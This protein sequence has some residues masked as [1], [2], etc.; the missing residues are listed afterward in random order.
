MNSMILQPFFLLLPLTWSAH[1]CAISVNGPAIR[2]LLRRSNM[3]KPSVPSK[4]PGVPPR[5]RRGISLCDEERGSEAPHQNGFKLRLTTRFRDLL[6][7]EN[8][9]VKVPQAGRFFNICEAEVVPVHD[10]HLTAE[11]VAKFCAPSW[12]IFDFESFAQSYD[13]SYHPYYLKLHREEESKQA[14]DFVPVSFIGKPLIYDCSFVNE[15]AADGKFRFN[16]LWLSPT[17][18]VSGLLLETNSRR[19]YEYR[20]R[21]R[22]SP[23]VGS[24]WD[25]VL[26]VYSISSFMFGAQQ[27]EPSPL[28]LGFLRSM[29]KRLP[30]EYFSHAYLSWRQAEFPPALCVDF[31]S[32][33]PFVTA[34]QQSQRSNQPIRLERTRVDFSRLLNSEQIHAVL[35]NQHDLLTNDNIC[36]ELS[37]CSQL[38]YCDHSTPSHL[39]PDLRACHDALRESQTLRHV[40]LPFKFLVDVWTS[41]DTPF[42][43]NPSILSLTLDLPCSHPGL[44][45]FLDGV[46]VNH[47]IK[48][49]FIHQFRFDER[50]IL[51]LSY[52]LVTVLPGHP[53]LKEVSI[54]IQNY[55]LRNERP[56]DRFVPFFSEWSVAAKRI[57]LVHFS[58]TYSHW[59]EPVL[60]STLFHDWWDRNVA[61]IVVMNWYKD[62][63]KQSENVLTESHQ[64]FPSD[65]IHLPTN[66]LLQALAVNRGNVYRAATTQVAVSDL[67]TANASILF[68]MLHGHLYVPVRGKLC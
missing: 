53:S 41:N 42:T 64:S 13:L 4:N 6:A 5:H 38:D 61:P 43:S 28:P 65:S 47:R 58:F 35:S 40:T 30:A 55:E 16:I 36:L 23:K 56:L 49:V 29:T 62:I 66:L 21:L 32:I 19:P 52:L 51:D 10:A 34:D 27:Q 63:Q 9:S 68:Q 14:I 1:V 2:D 59:S 37:C 54:S 24:T 67:T 45:F 25:M 60:P 26:H 39:I 15:F 17:V 22:I 44:P 57:N 18:F 3:F 20:V 48:S 11:G 31:L 33:F 46:T 12:Q 50:S 8:Y 7:S